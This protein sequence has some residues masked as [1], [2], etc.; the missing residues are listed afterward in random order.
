MNAIVL[1]DFGSVEHLTLEEI[2]IPK[3][4][5][6][7]VLV[8]TKALSIN[9]VDIK[10]RKGEALADTL[11]DFN[12][13]VLGWDISGV[14]ERVGENVTD[15][16]EG[17]EVFGMVN[18]VGHGM[19]YAEYVVAPAEHLTIKPN[20]ISHSEAAASTLA[21]LTAWQ[22]FHHFGKLKE[23]RQGID[24][25]CFWGCRPFCRSNCKTYWRSRYRH[26]LS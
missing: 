20:N 26:I 9:P 16:K 7:E 21:A 24:S 2:P 10:T 11:K 1:K 13:I 17:Q 23:K 14:I 6:N 25:W 4:S 19:A 18:F 3:I 5:D 15:F 12:P 22:A 8:K